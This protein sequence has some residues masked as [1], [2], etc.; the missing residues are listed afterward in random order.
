[1]GIF[2]PH[3]S[4]IVL[5][6]ASSCCLCG[7]MTS[8]G[9]PNSRTIRMDSNPVADL[10]WL[11]TFNLHIQCFCNVD[12]LLEMERSP[13]QTSARTTKI[14]AKQQGDHQVLVSGFNI[15]IYV[16]INPITIQISFRQKVQLAP[17]FTWTW[18]CIWLYGCFLNHLE[19]LGYGLSTL[20]AVPQ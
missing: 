15:F 1:M 5:P 3:K 17:D 14:I 8:P 20:H 4:C 11:G 19:N 13:S 18:G 10:A 7:A 6:G 2:R 12:W 16:W 9:W